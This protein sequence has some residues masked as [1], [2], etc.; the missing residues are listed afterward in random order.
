MNY[1]KKYKEALERAKTIRFGNPQSGTAN[2]VCEEIFPELRESEDEKNRKWILEYLYDGLR[3][4]DEQFKDHFKLA[5]DWLEKQ[6]DSH[7]DYFSTHIETLPDGGT[8]RHAIGYLKKQKE[9]KPAENYLEWRNIVYYVLKEWLGIGQYMDMFP[10]NDIVKT[11]Q[12]RYSLPKPAEWSE[13]DK[14]IITNACEQLNCYA[15][16]YHNA[17][18]DIRAKEVYE[19]AD[20]LKSLCPQSKQEWSEEDERKLEKLSFLLTLSEERE[21]ITPTER[22]ELGT[23]LK[24]LRPKPHWKPSEEQMEELWNVISYIEEPG[25]NFLGV[26]ELL[27]SLYEQLKKL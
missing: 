4:A 27:E 1:E 14:K 10:F 17:G 3:K 22:K 8:T 11:L 9:Q 15:K 23:F 5:I 19:V 12:E 20:E 6:K 2:V 16:S 25:S 26:P 18:N 7:T 21:S 13:E 24:S